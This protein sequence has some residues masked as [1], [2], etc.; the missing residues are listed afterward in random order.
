MT[1]SLRCVPG[2]LCDARLFAPL[3]ERLGGDVAAVPLAGDT[4]GQAAEA[5]IAAT[6]A[7]GIALG[8]S[9][10]GF[11]VLEALRRAPAH[12]AGAVLVASQAEPDSPAAATER[13]R[14]AALFVQSP[15]ALTDDLLP[16][17]VG[18]LAGAAVHATIRAMAGKFAPRDFAAQ[19]AIAASR[20]DSRDLRVGVPLLVV[21]GTEDRLC[22]PTRAAAT[23]RALG[24]A[25]T[26]VEAGHF[27]PLEAPDA[28][29][30]AIAPWLAR[31][32]RAA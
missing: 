32:D 20:A 29:A 27:V 18:T 4:T 6:P 30:A 1:L 23:A 16:R 11:V 15:G 28:L 22:P 9:L 24:A 14:Q 12:F 25:F 21:A 31:L 5:L 17:V 3:F 13:A 7:G 8:F 26:E 19:S 10:G 2:T